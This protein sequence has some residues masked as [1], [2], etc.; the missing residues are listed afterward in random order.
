MTEYCYLY[1]V[2]LPFCWVLF[3]DIVVGQLLRRL[4]HPTMYCICDSEPIVAY[5]MK[6]FLHSISPSITLLVSN[7]KN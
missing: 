1:E 2:V 3:L 6:D 5:H 7:I 4:H